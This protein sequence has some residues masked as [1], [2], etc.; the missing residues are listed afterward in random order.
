[1]TFTECIL[2]LLSLGLDPTTNADARGYI[3]P[4]G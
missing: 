3:D 4:N 1:M 2:W